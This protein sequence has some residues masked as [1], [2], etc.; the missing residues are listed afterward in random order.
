MGAYS[1]LRIPYQSRKYTIRNTLYSFTYHASRIT[2]MPIEITPFT[3]DHIPAA[4]ELLAQRHQADRTTFPAFPAEY[5]QPTDAQTALEATW[6]RPHPIGA[7]ALQNGR[8]LAYLL[9]ELALQPIWGR[10]GWIRPAGLAVAP[11]QSWQLIRD[12]YAVIGQ[13][14]LNYGCF[15][16]FA[17]IPIADPALVH[18]WFTLSFG[19]EQVH[20]RLDLRQVEIPAPPIPDDIEIRRATPGDKPA[21]AEIS[22]VIWSH[23]VKAPTWAISLPEL[24]AEARTNWAEFVDE[25]TAAI[26]LAYDQD[27]RVVGVT[28]CYA[29]EASNRN[30]LLPENTISLTVAGTRP[31]VR[32]RGIGLA[33]T[34]L[35]LR[36]AQAAGY[37]YA[38]IDWRS[39]SLAADRFWPRQGFQPIAYR[40]VRR[41]DERISW[42]NG[43]PTL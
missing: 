17:L 43:R 36:Y 14:W 30:I 8:L 13:Q 11:G 40:L 23:L 18:T 37:T 12:L 42:A 20:A 28:G 16:H 3:P 7:V 25:P 34:R 2:N 24:E 26:W 21:L 6:Q 19:L 1:V 38:D 22:D 41:V 4:A 10:T 9:G 35:C 27:G 15:A 31:W 39:A 33:L 32:G 29:Q 5:E